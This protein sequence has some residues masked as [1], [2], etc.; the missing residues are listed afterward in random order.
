MTKSAYPTVPGHSYF[1]VDIAVTSR[2][3]DFQLPGFQVLVD[4]AASRSII[5]AQ[6][7]AALQA[8]PTGVQ[9]SLGRVALD[10]TSCGDVELEAVI[11]AI[12]PVFSPSVQGILG[13]DFLSNFLVEFDYTALKLVLRPKGF[14]PAADLDVMEGSMKY[15]PGLFYVD[16]WLS[17]GE[18][19]GTAPV[20]AIVDT[21]ASRTIMNWDAAA[22]L[23]I[24]PGSALLE[25][26]GLQLAGQN[27]QP[28]QVKE[29][30]AGSRFGPNTAVRPTYLS[31]ADIPG[32]AA[33]GITSEPFMLLGTDVIEQLGSFQMSTAAQKM[34]VPRSTEASD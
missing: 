3:Q 34:W 18:T 8:R 1:T 33:F 24:E 6:I 7:A 5:S 26:R 21:G 9:V 13:L 28:L 20:K 27:G 10:G 31:V 12:P 16:V 30:L 11:G 23:G 19:E 32:F 22:T 4:T 2:Q 25:D 17:V 29:V 14:A 15:P